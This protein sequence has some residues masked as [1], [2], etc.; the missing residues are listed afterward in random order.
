MIHETIEPV[1][2]YL[3]SRQLVDIVTYGIGQAKIMSLKF[4][5]LLIQQNV[6]LYIIL[7]QKASNALPPR[8]AIAALTI[9]KI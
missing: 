5:T 1:D 2:N 7:L 8:R 4:P 6:S 3:I 9:Y